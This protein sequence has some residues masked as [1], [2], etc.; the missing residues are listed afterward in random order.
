MTGD[1]DFILATTGGLPPMA[2]EPNIEFHDI[3]EPG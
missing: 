3:Q 2:V 1:F